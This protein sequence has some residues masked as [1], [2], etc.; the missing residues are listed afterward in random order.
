MPHKLGVS[1]TT[2]AYIGVISGGVLLL[3]TGRQAANAIGKDGLFGYGKSKKLAAYGKSKEKTWG[4]LQT[5]SLGL[6]ALIM[7]ESGH[8]SLERLKAARKQSKFD[9]T[10]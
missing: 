7:L 2:W 10:F 6:L 1:E 3:T 5:L 8:D 9:N 4:D